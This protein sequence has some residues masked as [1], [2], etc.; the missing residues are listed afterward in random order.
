MVA[1]ERSRPVARVGDKPVPV[2]TGVEVTISPDNVATIKGPRGQLV[3][4]FQPEMVI[5]VADGVIRVDRTSNQ[6]RVKAL[7]GLTRALL[8]NM[9]TGVS[10]GYE[11]ALDLV[12]TGYRVQEA[13]GKVVLQVGFSHTV[14]FGLVEDVAVTVASPTRIVLSGCD[15]QRVGQVA[16]QIRAI[17]PPDH[18]KGKGIRYAGEQVRLKPGKSAARS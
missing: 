6:R 8:N 14:E 7:H 17:R 15:K 5:A 10:E 9:V 4:H 11:R 13:G 2:P 18:Y 1:Q 16:A 3:Q 12:G